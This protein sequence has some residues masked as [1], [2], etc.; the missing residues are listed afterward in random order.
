MNPEKPRSPRDEL[1]ARL[2]TLLLGELPATEAV[3]LREL[4]AK[5]AQLAE[6]HERLKRAIDLVREAS[7]TVTEPATAQAAPLKLSN[8]RRQ[9]LFAHFKTVAPKEFVPHPRHR[10]WSWR[11]R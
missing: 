6:L 5:D 9:K 11:R 8:E 1:E 2:T 3:A 10:E 4:I 7:A